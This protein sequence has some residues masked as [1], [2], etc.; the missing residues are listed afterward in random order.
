M[1]FNQSH[2]FDF[3]PFLAGIMQFTQSFVADPLRNIINQK[4]AVKLNESHANT[5]C[6]LIQPIMPIVPTSGIPRFVEN[7]MVDL[8]DYLMN[9]IVGTRG[10]LNFSFLLNQITKGS[11]VVTKNLF[12]QYGFNISQYL[13]TTISIPSFS[14]SANIS[15]RNMTV[16]IL[17]FSIIGLN[18]CDVW[19]V[20]TPV[21]SINSI[22]ASYVPHSLNSSLSF[23]SIELDLTAS[24][25]QSLLDTLGFPSHTSVDLK[26][27]FSNVSFTNSLLLLLNSSTMMRLYHSYPSDWTNITC[28]AMPLNDAYVSKF[29]AHSLIQKIQYTYLNET[30]LLNN[31]E[32]WQKKFEDILNAFIEGPVKN[33]L[34]DLISSF[35]NAYGHSSLCPLVPVDSSF[36]IDEILM[37]YSFAP[38]ACFILIFGLILL[39]ISKKNQKE[40]QFSPE[41]VCTF[42]V[43]F[44]F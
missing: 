41:S 15:E 33:Q 2:V 5:T 8:I 20:F 24:L 26:V 3:N 21:T 11:D 43:F 14:Q 23:E 10:V 30:K 12:D 4:V 34:N 37:I 7:K 16:S 6:V 18:T 31:T 22:P 29:N 36:V 38:C 28:V 1:S 13:T 9:D 27:Y 35:V 32:V 25:G 42:F 39:F 17:N 19:S 44:F 40:E